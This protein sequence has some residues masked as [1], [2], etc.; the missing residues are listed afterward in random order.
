MTGNTNGSPAD[1]YRVPVAALTSPS[2]TYQYI[3]FWQRVLAAVIDSIITTLVMLPPLYALFGASVFGFDEVDKPGTLYTV[4]S[5]VGPAIIVFFFW[6]K[7]SA[8]PG[9]MLIKSKIIDANTGGQPT[10]SQ[11][12]VR[13]LGYFVSCIP[14]GL[15]LF[16]VGWDQRKQG[17]HDKMAK[18]VVVKR[19]P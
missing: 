6:I 5:L 7:K 8:T 18:T 11:W 15:G 10:V 14:L 17:W 2:D 1:P 3:G 4:I 13:Y 12:V 19:I 16:A 9:K